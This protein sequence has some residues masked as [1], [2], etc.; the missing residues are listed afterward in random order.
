[1]IIDGSSDGFQ[2]LN[3][4]ARSIDG[5]YVHGIA[6]NYGSRRKHIWSYGIG[7]SV[8]DNAI[9]WPCAKAAGIF[10]PSFIYEDSYCESGSSN[11]PPSS[12]TYLTVWDCE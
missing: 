2:A 8:T 9:S 1:M 11:G 6:I 12:T 4:T 3:Y 5:P 7:F 10:P